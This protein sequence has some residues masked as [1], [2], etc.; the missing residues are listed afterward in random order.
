MDLYDDKCRIIKTVDG[1]ELNTVTVAKGMNSMNMAKL[2]DSYLNVMSRDGFRN[3]IDTGTLLSTTHRTLQRSV[4]CFALG[5]LVG[6]SKQVNSDARNADAL[7]T[8]KK[9]AD[10][11]EKEEISMGLFI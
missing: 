6:I 2:L 11:I 5:L 3:G 7:I 1:Q 10:M 4:V 8:A 9:I